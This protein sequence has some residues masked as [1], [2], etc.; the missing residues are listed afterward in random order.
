VRRRRSRVASLVLV[1]ASALVLIP[2]GAIA[3]AR[4]AHRRLARTINLELA[5]ETDVWGASVRPG[6]VEACKNAGFTAVR[7]PV[8]WAKHTSPNPPDYRIDPGHFAR[9]DAVVKQ[10]LSLG[11]AVIVDNHKDKKLMADPA[12]HRAR[13]LATTRQIAEH[14][15][16]WPKD[17]LIEPMAEPYG[18]LDRVW[19]EYFKE[20][21]ATVRRV[22][23]ERVVLVGPPGYNSPKYL[24]YL[25]L[26]ADDRLIVCVH[27]YVPEPF[28]FQGEDFVP[29]K[30]FPAGVPW[31]GTR[32]EKQ[33]VESEYDLAVAWGRQ[34]KRPIFVEEFGST[35]RADLASRVRWTAWC[36]R[37]AEAR[38]LSWGVWAFAPSFSIYDLS[39]GAWRRPL[40]RALIPR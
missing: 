11:L 20:A 21:L 12:A 33:V 26:P 14:Y 15:R 31:K 34:T 38:G 7:L 19:S 29:G 17:V 2:T 18:E 35:D 40:L 32:K 5:N 37:V 36:R 22:D 24:K 16:L 8:S 6:H 23:P 9:V 10:C 28:V 3:D 27:I 25:E 30:T 13:W 4:Q 1:L 39:K